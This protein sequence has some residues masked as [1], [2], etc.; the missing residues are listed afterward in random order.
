MHR[1]VEAVAHTTYTR[2][3]PPPTPSGRDSTTP[4]HALPEGQSPLLVVGLV[5]SELTSSPAEWANRIVDYP[6]FVSPHS[7]MH[8][9]G[10]P[11]SAAQELDS[12]LHTL[13]QEVLSL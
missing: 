13:L 12:V 10:P 4:A 7:G 9:A 11:P 6:A 5:S 3:Y 8:D 2:L 1:P